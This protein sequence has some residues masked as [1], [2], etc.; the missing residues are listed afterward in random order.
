MVLRRFTRVYA[1]VYLH[2]LRTW[3]Y[4]FSFINSAVNMMLWISI[5][6]LGALLFIPREK[7]VIVAPQLFW[8]IISWTLMSYTVLNIAGWTIW[9]AV[10]TGLV[11]EHILHKTRLSLFFAG[12]L[13]VVAFEAAITLPLVYAIVKAVI[14]EDFAL[15]RNPLLLLYGLATIELMA[16]SYSL[17]LS[18]VGLC[19]R[20]P[21]TMLDISNFIVFVVGGIAAPVSMLPEPLRRIALAIPYS[22]AAEVIRYAAAGVKPYLGLKTE[23]VLS[24]SAAVVMLL[25]SLALYNYVEDKVIRKHGVKGVGRM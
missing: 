8:G 19:L 16:L 12:R 24:A 5:F 25:T 20:I 15:A 7:I 1:M 2:A 21:G 18:A 23:I 13:I 22:H 14:G 10:A 4:K 17:L 6:L 11:E 3:R 9:F